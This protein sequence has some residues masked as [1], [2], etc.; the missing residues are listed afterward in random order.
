MLRVVGERPGMRCLLGEL[1]E[2][3]GVTA[4]TLR[5][6]DD[7][8]LVLPTTRAAGQRRYA[9]SAVRDVGVILFLSDLRPGSWLA[10]LLL[11][12]AQH[13]AARTRDQACPQ[14]KPANR[15]IPAKHQHSQAE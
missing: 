15:L 14:A 4:T 10:L 7:L 12:S 1:S 11:A 9:A 6:Y 8:G 2:R 3:T 5:Y 13:P